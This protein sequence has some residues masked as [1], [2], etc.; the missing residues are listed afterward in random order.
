RANGHEQPYRVSLWGVGNES[1]GCGGNMTPEHYADLYKQY[2][3][4]CPDYPGAPLK[5]IVSGANAG[6]YHWTEV[7]MK[8]IPLNS[9]YGISMHYYTFPTGGWNPRGSATQFTEAEYLHTLVGAMKMEEIVS[10][11]IAV[12]DKYDPEK[13][14]SLMVD[15]WG[16]WTDVEPGTNKAFMF[17]Q[18]SLRDALVAATTLNI[19][20]NH[21]DRVRGA[22]LAQTVNVI[23]SLIL[24]MGDQMVL[25]PTYHVFDLYTVHQGAKLLSLK[26][27]SPFYKIGNDSVPSVN[28]SASVDSFG[29]I[30]IS[31]V[32]LDAN[33]SITIKTTL[34][35]KA[36]RSISGRILTSGKVT[37]IN[38]FDDPGHIIIHLFGNARISGNVL[39]ADL[40]AKSIVVLELK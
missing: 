7:M 4:F 24:T 28:A 35:G 37:D 39:T 13:R 14:V 2:A 31:L 18:N 12:M 6:D 32:N 8:N 19:F 40:P 34:S 22:N 26:F 11:H 30:H 15:E 10:K 9:M 25:T 36:P 29:T 20:N 3:S 23:H 38:S 1:W 17:Q 21:A 16:V 5:K 27:N 33:K